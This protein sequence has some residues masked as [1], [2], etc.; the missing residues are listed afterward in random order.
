MFCARKKCYSFFYVQIKYIKNEEGVLNRTLLS[1]LTVGVLLLM[2]NSAYAATTLMQIGRSPFYQPPLTTPE[3]LISM[4]QE[5]E[6]SVKT[7]FS[8]A[9][10]TELF[11]PFVSQIT[12]TKIETLEYHKGDKFEWMFF[13]KKG[14]GTVRVAKDVTWGSDK[15][16]TGFQFD[17]DNDGQRHTFVVPLGCGNIALMGSK[18]IPVQAAPPAEPVVAAPPPNQAPSC[19]MTV[20]PQQAYCGEPVTVD[21]SGSVD[22]DGQISKMTVA[23]VDA[24]GQVVKETVVEDGSLV[25]QV[26]MPCGSNSLKVTLTDNEGLS[27][28]PSQCQSTIVGKSKTRFLADIGYYNMPDPGNYLFGRVGLEYKISDQWGVLGM[29]GVAPHIEGIDGETAFLI[30][31]LGEYTFASRYFIDLGLGGWISTGDNDLDTED[32]QI[33]AIA[34]IGARV[35]GE[36]DA[37]NASLFLEVRAGVDEFDDFVDYGRF[38]FGVRFRF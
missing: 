11:E 25:S 27:S 28:D 10:R 30:D 35:Y 4:V 21:A 23:V 18:P 9:G 38:G 2:L 20:T 13:K 22:S 26:P 15:T 14:K 6:E 33:D 31:L 17:I 1:V 37:F 5:Q 7:G 8:K 16:F 29:V 34:A 12:T 3:S 36:P 32:S 24:N 19:E